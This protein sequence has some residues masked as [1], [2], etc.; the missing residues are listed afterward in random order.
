MALVNQVGEFHGDAVFP[1]Q[2]GGQAH[3]F[4]GQGGGEARLK[5]VG[6]QVTGELFGETA[7]A[8][9]A[10]GNHIGQRFQR[11]ARLD[12]QGQRFRHQHADAHRQQV[13][14]DFGHHPVA[15]VAAIDDMGS[16]G[17][18]HRLDRIV[19]GAV[20]AHHHGQGAGGRAV[21]AAADRGV[22]HGDAPRGAFV[23]DA[24]DGGGRIGGQ[25][26]IDIARRGGRHYALLAH[27][28]RLH[29]PWHGQRGEHGVAAGHALRRGVSPGGAHFQQV[30]SRLPAQV[31]HRKLVAGLNHIGG[32]RIAHIAHANETSFHLIY[33]PCT[34]LRSGDTPRC[35][36]AGR[37]DSDRP[38]AL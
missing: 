35:G 26:N 27:H 19:G 29:I 33:A 38:A 28:H 24:P 4:G 10:V 25:V 2:V 22:Q 8:A 7:V 20:A 18:Q 36:T 1:A 3:I 5:V 30:G 34:I 11:H 9:A 14:A 21:H 16:D 31:V 13:V 12:A 17:V 15:D 6:E 23:V 37:P 32:H